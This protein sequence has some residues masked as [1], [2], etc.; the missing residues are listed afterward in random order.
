[1]LMTRTFAIAPLLAV[2]LCVPAAAAELTYQQF[3]N[4]VAIY[5]DGQ[6]LNGYFNVVDVL[7][8]PVAPTIFTNVGFGIEPG[9]R[10][11]GQP[12]TYINRLLNA[13]PLDEPNSLGWSLLGITRTSTRVA[14]A[15]SPLG[16]KIDTSGQPD[17]NLFLANVH[18]SSP[19]PQGGFKARVQ[20]IDVGNLVA[21][22]TVVPEPT[23][24]AVCLAGL[25]GLA[26]ARRRLRHRNPCVWVI[27]PGW[28]SEHCG[29][30]LGA[31]TNLDAQ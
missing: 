7:I 26:T 13:D 15:G 24:F 3:G 23:G 25:L 30:I 22:L 6:E 29:F 12:F 18:L 4:S 17:G 16:Q 20:L 10:P 11:P 19:L 9:I 8:E 1:M 5:L 27:P 2:L 14:F 28:R 31:V 21:D